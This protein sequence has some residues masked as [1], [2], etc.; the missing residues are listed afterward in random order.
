MEQFD[1]VIK[2]VIHLVRFGAEGRSRDVKALARKMAQQYRKTVPELSAALASIVASEGSL[3][4]A[5]R[6]LPVDADS[7]LAL[8]RIVDAALAEK[9]VLP[10]AL[11]QQLRQLVAEHLDSSALKLAGLSPSKSA[12]LIGPPGVGKTMAAQWIA[13]ELRRPLVVLDLSSSISSFL[14]KTGQNVR[15]LFDFCKEFDCILLLDEV[16]AIAKKRADETDLG[17]LKRLVNVLL[18]EL[19]E[20]PEGSL[21]LAAT[22]HPDILDPAIWRRFDLTFNLP[23]PGLVERT[24]VLRRMPCL[25]SESMLLTLAD[26]SEG[27]NHAEIVSR[28]NAGRR[29]AVMN[30][31]DEQEGVIEAFAERLRLLPMARRHDISEKLI[32]SGFS[33]RRASELT[34]TSRN[35]LRKHAKKEVSA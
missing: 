4:S 12:L 31:S 35:T 29:S 14:G 1:S 18:Q 24:E 11:E 5:K 19:D 22:N 3:R 33:Q 26:I 16:D 28:V 21:V 23:L 9:P 25:T 13:R 6:P 27:M 7:R 34:G 17:E 10:A 30:K 32:S 2:D 8:A 20:W 15:Q